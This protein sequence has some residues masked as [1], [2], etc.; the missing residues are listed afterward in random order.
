MGLPTRSS[1]GED[2]AVQGIARGS[3]GWAEGLHRP[4]RPDLRVAPSR[5]GGGQAG[6]AGAWHGA[7]ASSIVMRIVER[8]WVAALTVLLVGGPLW[9][10]GTLFNLAGYENT[11]PAKSG[12]DKGRVVIVP[13][14]AVLGG[15][16]LDLSVFASS[17]GTKKVN[18]APFGTYEAWDINDPL[19]GWFLFYLFWDLPFSLAGD[20]LLLPVTMLISDR[21]SKK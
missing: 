18:A 5:S 10:C 12:P 21:D 1:H 7:C 16:R 15:L 2:R 3:K 14:A 13:Q 9:G 6:S 20:L 19:R 8:G 4:N 11:Q 17:V